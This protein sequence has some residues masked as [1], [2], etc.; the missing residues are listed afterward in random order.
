VDESIGECI[1]MNAPTG[2]V[3]VQNYSGKRDGSASHALKNLSFQASPGVPLFVMGPVGSGKVMATIL[4][5]LK[6]E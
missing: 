4:Y 6:L 3:V 5:K 2:K 1:L